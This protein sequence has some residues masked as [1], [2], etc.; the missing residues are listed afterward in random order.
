MTN[1][2]LAR[3]PA[4]SYQQ[5]SKSYVPASVLGPNLRECRVWL[6]RSRGQAPLQPHLPR[7]DA[8]VLPYVG[9]YTS[10]R[11]TCR[12]RETTTTKPVPALHAKTYSSGLTCLKLDQLFDEQGS[13]SK[14]NLGKRNL[15]HAAKSERPRSSSESLV[16]SGACT[17]E[18]R[19]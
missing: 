9:C 19:V 13:P 18:R 7:K 1:K 10:H 6:I 12:D 8:L 16:F 14:F 4:G 17:A 5:V 3:M 15:C 2:Q 11:P